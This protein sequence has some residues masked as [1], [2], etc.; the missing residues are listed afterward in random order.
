M[1][2]II[3]NDYTSTLRGDILTF[4]P[5]ALSMFQQIKEKLLRSNKI[6]LHIGRIIDTGVYVNPKPI[7]F[8]DITQPAENQLKVHYLSDIE[9]EDRKKMVLEK[10]LR[11]DNP[12]GEIP[13]LPGYD[14]TPKFFSIGDELGAYRNFIDDARELLRNEIGNPIQLCYKNDFEEIDTDKKN[15]SFSIIEGNLKEVNKGNIFTNDYKEILLINN[16]TVKP[17]NVSRDKNHRFISEKGYLCAIF[18]PNFPRDDAAFDDGKVFGQE[19][20]W[21][22]DPHQV[23]I[24]D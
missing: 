13:V 21:R 18:P 16:T 24:V 17:E 23:R 11:F 12:L 10:T 2:Q 6:E 3:F 4:S 22:F 20:I 1:K 8:F 7:K 14:Q 9:G 19:P 15:N 5:T